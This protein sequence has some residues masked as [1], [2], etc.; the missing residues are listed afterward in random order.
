MKQGVDYNLL[1][2]LILLNKHRNLKKV[3]FILEKTESAVS[4][5]LAKLREQIGDPLFIRTSQGLEPTYLLLSLLPSIEAGLNTIDNA[6]LNKVKFSS[7]DYDEPIRI[8][9]H[10]V[11]ISLYASDIYKAIRSHFPKP[12]ISIE[13]WT[14]STELRLLDN[15]VQI[16]INFM[17]EERIKT[18]YQSKLIDT[19][20]VI[21][22]PK[23]SPINTWEEAI[24]GEFVFFKVNDWNHS[25]QYFVEHCMKEGINLN[26]RMTTDDF[27]TAIRLS[28]EENMFL[29]SLKRLINTDR[30]KTIEIPGD[31]QFLFPMVSC[32]KLS[33][34][35]N[36][37]HTQLENIIRDIIN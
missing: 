35:Q 13:V 3:A 8:A 37:L 24:Y 27:A 31:F 28:I 4:K 12:V 26:Y 25:R 9:I 2:V 21:A 10:S 11:A 1:R 17:H 18:I 34:R 32:L 7:K 23:D 15:K 22:L 14:E 33:N 29:I 36:P 20:L 16:G 6:L 5:Y 30:L 19:T